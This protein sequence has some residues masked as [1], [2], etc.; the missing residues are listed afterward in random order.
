MKSPGSR[1]QTPLAKTSSHLFGTVEWAIMTA[2]Q[3][4]FGWLAVS[5][6]PLSVAL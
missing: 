5:L 6:V 2:K 1:P 3:S 4:D